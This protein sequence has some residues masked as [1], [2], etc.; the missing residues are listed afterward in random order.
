MDGLSAD[1]FQGVHLNYVPIVEGLL[2][3]NLRLYDI[4]IVDGNI[5]GDFGRRSVHKCG[6]TVRLLRYSNHKCYVNNIN[7]VFQYFC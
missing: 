1:H 4:D 5:T 7:A 3:L 2:T 6:N